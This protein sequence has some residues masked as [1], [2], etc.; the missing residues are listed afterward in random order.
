MTYSLNRYRLA[1]SNG[2]VMS[3]HRG[4]CHCGNIEVTF[5]TRRDAA[6][7]PLRACA[8]GFCRRHGMRAVS[9]PGG[10]A[11]IAIR[12]AGSVNRYRFGLKTADFLIC[13]NCGVYVAAILS[14]GDADWATLNVNVLEDAIEF[15]QES[16][17]VNY[18]AETEAERRARRRANWTPIV[19]LDT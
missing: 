11:A 12:D 4:H 9:D 19:R 15:I 18:D 3:I 10:Q 8:C 13:A 7:L 14:D 5:E 1:V 16:M 2:R 17:T 6:A